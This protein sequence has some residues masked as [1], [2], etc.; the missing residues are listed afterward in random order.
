MQML[1]VVH[2]EQIRQ[3]VMFGLDVMNKGTLNL[4][5]VTQV[6][7]SVGVLIDGALSFR[8]QREIPRNLNVVRTMFFTVSWQASTYRLCFIW[9]EK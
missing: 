4:C 7:A 2:W 9:G 1:H 5:S 6:K 8:G 3:R